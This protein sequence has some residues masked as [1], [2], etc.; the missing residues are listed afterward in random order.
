MKKVISL[1]LAIVLISTVFVSCSG[2][3]NENNANLLHTYDSCYDDINRS[4]VAE[5]EKLCD[6]IINGD[7]LVDI[8]ITQ[9]EN[10]NRLYYTSFPLAILVKQMAF[11]EKDGNIKIEY[12]N[13]KDT[14]KKMVEDFSAKVNQI[15]TDCG[16][17]SVSDSEYLLNLYSYIS[18]KTTYDEKCTSTYDAIVNGVGSSS[19]YASAFEYLLLQAG[20]SA[21]SIYGL[22][23]QGVSF[24]TIADFNGEKF[25]FAPFNEYKANKGFGLSFFALT[26]TDVIELGFTDGFKY[27][28]EESVVFDEAS[29]EFKPLRGTVSYEYD[30]NNI[31]AIKG[32]GETVTV[33]LK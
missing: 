12:V 20:I 16:Y 26:Y 23:R 14:H 17:G 1:V 2:E 9:I 24:M 11:N 6:A 7:V 4:A 27:S 13:D 30:D 5:Y 32:N 19:S 22:N 8:D 18:S 21:T 29:A 33:K 10:I 25:I 15:M 3:K 31:T 28:N